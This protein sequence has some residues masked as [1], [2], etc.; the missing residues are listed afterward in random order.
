MKM[1]SSQDPH[2]VKKGGISMIMEILHP[3]E[4]G[5]PVS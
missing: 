2:K 5:T 4:G 1:A 3:W